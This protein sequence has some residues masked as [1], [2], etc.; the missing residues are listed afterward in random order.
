M[1]TWLSLSSS[2]ANCKDNTDYSCYCKDS[3][4]VSSI[5]DCVS[6]W[7][8]DASLVAEALSFFVGLCA[9][10]I[11]KNPGIVSN[12]PETV[13]LAPTYGSQPTPTCSDSAPVS[14]PTYVTT[15]TVSAVNTVPCTISTGESSGYTIPGSSTVSTYA[16][17]VTVPQVAFTTNTVTY[18]GSSSQTVNVVPGTPAP[19]YAT[20]T[21]FGT[22]YVP[23]STA[24]S[25]AFTGAAAKVGAAGLSGA[26]FAAALAALAL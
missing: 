23:T 4:F 7:E 6:A 9:D 21:G 15:V 16:T 3:G 19:V 5:Y 1:N 12:C 8:G 11:P 20:T 22:M 25:P 26:A 24:N 17:V 13:T 2:T 18:S 10:F 14:V